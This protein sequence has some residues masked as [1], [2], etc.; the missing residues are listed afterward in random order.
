MWG[1]GGYANGGVEAP[2]LLLPACRPQGCAGFLLHSD[3]SQFV[4]KNSARLYTCMLVAEPA[5]PAVS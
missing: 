5:T 3:L 1:S 4:S 2:T